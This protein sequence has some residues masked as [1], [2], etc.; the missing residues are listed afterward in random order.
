M[1]LIFGIKGFFDEGI[2]YLQINVISTI[3]NYLIPVYLRKISDEW[4]KK[5][6]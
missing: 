3:V 4:G 5:L 6:G 1:G 2:N